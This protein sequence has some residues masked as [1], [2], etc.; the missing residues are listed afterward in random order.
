MLS[1]SS[2]GVLSNLLQQKSPTAEIIGINFLRTIVPR[3]NM[4]I[5]STVGVF[6][7]DKFEETPNEKVV[8][9]SKLTKPYF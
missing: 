6:C 1:T 4:P 2:F 8:N 7:Y 5:I 3:K 9:I